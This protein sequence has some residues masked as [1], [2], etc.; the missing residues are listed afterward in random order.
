MGMG[1]LTGAPVAVWNASTVSD[2]AGSDNWEASQG[3]RKHMP[4]GMLR[5]QNDM[6]SPNTRTFTPLE[7]K[8]AAADNPYGPA[9]TTTTSDFA[10]NFEPPTFDFF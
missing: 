5:S 3:D 1:R 10:F 8:C 2:L 6:A 7:F 4:L 9:P